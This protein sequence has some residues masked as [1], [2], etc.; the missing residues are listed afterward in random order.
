MSL[1]MLLTLLILSSSHNDTV[2]VIDV[3]LG[4]PVSL[5]QQGVS[6]E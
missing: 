3:S 5:P 4:G 2:F 6:P 1:N